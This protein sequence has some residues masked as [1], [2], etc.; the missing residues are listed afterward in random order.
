[1]VL[2]IKIFLCRIY[3]VPCFGET[4]IPVELL[5]IGIKMMPFRTKYLI[6]TCTNLIH[7]R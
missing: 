6:L 7:V 4:R 5:S 3:D 1:M 2:H